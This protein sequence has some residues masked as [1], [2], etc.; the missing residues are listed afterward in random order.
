MHYRSYGL[1]TL[2][3]LESHFHLQ[4]LKLFS[5]FTTLCTG[6]IFEKI[7][8]EHISNYLYVLDK[9][10]TKRNYRQA[11]VQNHAK[12]STRTEV[13][14][15]IERFLYTIQFTHSRNSS[16]ALNWIHKS[17]FA[18]SIRT[19]LFIQFDPNV[20]LE[21]SSSYNQSAF[22]HL[23]SVQ[24]HVIWIPFIRSTIEHSYLTSCKEQ[25]SLQLF[26][27]QWPQ[28][29]FAQWLLRVICT[30]ETDA[31][32]DEQLF[33]NEPSLKSAMPNPFHSNDWWIESSQSCQSSPHCSH[34][35]HATSH[36]PFSN[37]LLDV[38]LLVLIVHFPVIILIQFCEVEYFSPVIDEISPQYIVSAAI[39]CR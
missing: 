6:V 2:C 4:V 33:V 21:I 8:T 12:N 7:S 15:T 5:E 39:L 25:E 34:V 24:C 13:V 32:F 22:D 31:R 14:K 19:I 35:L 27:I 30:L 3:M 37:R 18:I 9:K 1:F 17:R 26:I 36:Q 38:F 10:W 20:Q 11:K 23:I 28:H 16:G 29:L